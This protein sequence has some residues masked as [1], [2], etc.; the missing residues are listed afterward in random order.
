MTDRDYYADLGVP[1]DASSDEIGRAFRRLA[2]KHHPDRNPGDRQAEERFKRIAEAYNVLNDS[3]AR[4]AYDQGGSRQVEE[5]TGFHGFSTTDDVFSRFGDI[6]GD[7]F[8]DRVRQKVGPERGGDYEVGLGISEDLALRGGPAS[9]SLEASFACGECGGSGVRSGA[10]RTCSTCRGSGYVGQRARKSGGFFSVSTP[11]PRC[12]GTGVDPSAACPR[13]GGRGSEAGPRTIE[14]TIPAGSGRGTILRLRGMGA[15]GTR[16]GPPGDLR[17]RL[18]LEGGRVPGGD[19]LHLRRE[20][21]VDLPT[22]TLGG[23]AEI[24]LPD[25]TLEMKIPPGTQPGQ[26]FRLAGQ[27]R[28]LGPGRQ[29][30]LLVTVRVRVPTSLTPDEKRLFETLRARPSP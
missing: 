8:G 18:H 14:L 6:F 5:D 13:C 7:L 22:A 25:R 27:G 24:A 12:H 4:A 11:C 17:V 20:V 3:K 29:G 1:R 10:S 19:D 2:A 30:D 16:G 21:T 26:Q 23:A 9:L 28:A 15:P